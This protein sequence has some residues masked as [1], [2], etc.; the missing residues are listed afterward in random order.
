MMVDAQL[1]DIQNFI[2]DHLRGQAG[3]VVAVDLE[4]NF[5]DSGLLDSFAILSMIMMLESRFAIKFQ[6]E[7]L[8]NPALRRVCVLAQTVR[9]KL[10]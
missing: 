2:L 7:E 9:T 3:G 6:A 5:I 8:A 4:T 1:A 10:G